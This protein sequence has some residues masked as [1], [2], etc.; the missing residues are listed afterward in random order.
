MGPNTCIYT[1]ST[2]AN[3]HMLLKHYSGW[4]V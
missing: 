3:I 4:Q 2:T 1:A